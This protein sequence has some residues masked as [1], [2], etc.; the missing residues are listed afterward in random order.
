M[1]RLM[2]NKDQRNNISVRIAIYLTYIVQGIC[3]NYFSADRA[4][5]K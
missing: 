3:F 2:Q 5:I 4:T 1:I